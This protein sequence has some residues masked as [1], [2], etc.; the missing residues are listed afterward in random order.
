MQ[1]RMI[2]LIAAS[3]GAVLIWQGAGR[4][5]AQ[6][7]AFANA[8]EAR[9]ALNLARSQQRAARGRGERLEQQAAQSGEAAEKSLQQAAALAARIQQA[10][11]GV[12][13]AEASLEIVDT[14]SATLARRLAQRREPLVR[15]TGALQSMARRP[16]TLSALQ[17]GSLKDLVY[18]QAVLESTIPQIHARTADLRDDLDRARALQDQRRE[19]VAEMRTSEQ[20]LAERRR[21]LVALA[22]NQRATASR[23]TGDATREAERAL[24]LGEQARDLDTL[25][26]E[27][28]QAGELRGQLAALPGPMMRPAQP[29]QA[30]AAAAPARPTP[31]ATAPPGRYQLPVAGRVVTGFGESAQG[32]PRQSGIVLAPRGNAQVVAPGAGRVAF[33]GPYRGYGDI[34]IIEHANGW[35]SLVTGLDRLDTAVGARVTAGS[36]LGLAAPR[37]PQITLELR[38]KGTPLNPIDYLR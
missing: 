30:S 10:E 1:R 26:G 22:A 31:A 6:A 7:P 18:T 2:A 19:T 35:T 16:M 3:V 37:T 4:A 8:G 12:A 11:A 14:Q 32:A 27:L 21:N 15:L 36:P 13:A 28:E 25:V 24:A 9:E 34:V 5:D 17:P 33:A 23:A 29:E 38:Q 20:T